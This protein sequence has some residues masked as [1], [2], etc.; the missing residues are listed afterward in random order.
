MIKNF[1]GALLGIPVGG[2][3]WLATNNMLIG[4]GVGIAV[5]IGWDVWRQRGE[6]DKD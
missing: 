2:I 4:V 3:A 6:D 1:P 5:G